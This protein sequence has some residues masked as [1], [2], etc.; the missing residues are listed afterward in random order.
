M[1]NN[2]AQASN[3]NNNKT[4]PHFL[5]RQFEMFRAINEFASLGPS[6]LL[7]ETAPTG[8][9]HPVLLLPGLLGDDGTT[10]ILRRYLKY[11]GYWSHRW[12]LGINLGRK[13]IGPDGRDIIA[14]I[15]G[16]MEKSGGR[17][18]SL[19]GISMGG[20]IA[21]EIAKLEPELVRQVITI[22]SPFNKPPE[23]SH[24]A[25]IYHK[26]TGEKEDTQE[27][28]DALALPPEGIPTT[29]IYSRS[30]GLVSWQACKEDDSELTNNIE[31][32]SSH[33]GMGVN[34]AVLYAV[35]DRLALP[36][37]GWIPFDRNETLWRSIAYGTD[38]NN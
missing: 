4:T 1:N 27:L 29:A 21:R 20:I 16:I 37:G 35:A 12:R 9:G 34:P 11:K 24:T 32:F 2:S 3:L 7:L 31:V 17:R 15:K 30:D 8:D 19:V 33:L 10:L 26:I 38:I 23:N 5:L 36:E 14:R 13:S 28:K 18:L 25:S 22:G 6:S